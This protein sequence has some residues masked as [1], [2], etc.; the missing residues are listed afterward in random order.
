M[1][2]KHEDLR[3]LGQLISAWIWALLLACVVI[4]LLAHMHRETKSHLQECLGVCVEGDEVW[5]FETLR[6]VAGLSAS[7]ACG[8]V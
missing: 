4:A 3:D 7:T 1:L 2:P 6:Y 8:I 5:G